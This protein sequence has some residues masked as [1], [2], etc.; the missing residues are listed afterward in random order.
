[1]AIDYKINQAISVEQFIAVLNESGLG[2]RRPVDDIECVRGMLEHNNLCVTAWD[3]N[4]LIGVARSMTDFH[5]ACYLSDLAVAKDYQGQGVGKELLIITQKQLGP[6]CKLILIAAPA[7]N[8]YYQ[9][10]GFS[11]NPRC[12]TLAPEQSI[13]S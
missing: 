6:H 13:K 10:I 4:Q 7:A 12:W 2:E 1:M 11:H 8:D 5:Y 3:N 9:S